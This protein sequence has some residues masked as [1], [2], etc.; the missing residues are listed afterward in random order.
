LVTI[1]F[2]EFE[3]QGWETVGGAYHDYFAQ[4]TSQT[5]PALLD[6][7]IATEA[8]TLLDVACGPGYVAA[9]AAERGVQVVGLDFSDLMVRKA[10][11]AY[12]HI[13][14]VE[15]DAQALQFDAG[16][17]DAVSMNFGML[18]LDKPED[19]LREAH[20]VL[21]DSGVFAFTVWGTPDESLAFKI[22]LSAIQDI[23]DTN[24][25][26]P[27]GPPFF[28]FSDPQESV[29]CMQDAGFAN[30][31]TK[32]LPLTWEL[33]TPSDLF[34]AFYFGTP[35]TGGLLR[36]QTKKRLDAIA[37][38]VTSAAQEFVQDGV[39]KVPMSALL[40]SGTKATA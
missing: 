21:S 31:R 38:R 2:H 19:A 24:V 14:F 36:A 4:L 15:G 33:A 23:G 35:R 32:L 18:H 17:F 37:D 27:P 7:V 1:S 28:R 9:A 40:V 25:P 5:I 26:L 39:V 16:E 6:E 10:K 29:R 12:P 8:K 13:E 30:C 20:R 22:V 3:H 34:K 11:T